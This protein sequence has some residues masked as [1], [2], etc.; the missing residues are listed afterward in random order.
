MK[1]NLRL[2]SDLPALFASPQQLNHCF[3]NIINNSVKYSHDSCNIFIDAE[4]HGGYYLIKIT[5]TG[6]GM[7][8]D[9]LNHVFDEFY[10]AD[11]ARHDFDSSGLGMPIAK[12]IVE[13]HGG[14]IW[15][16]SEGLGKGT[17][18]SFTLPKEKMK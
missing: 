5:D 8:N 4:D 11:P 17:T 2:S 12:R 14:K 15:V 7:N 6:I 9:Q 13:K 3:L 16:E 18:V 10:K 1:V